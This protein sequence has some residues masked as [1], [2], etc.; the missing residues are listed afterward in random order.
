MDC[1]GVV[2]ATS[3]SQ[4]SIGT[5]PNKKFVR[6]II[7]YTILRMSPNS[8]RSSGVLTRL[9]SGPSSSSNVPLMLFPESEEPPQSS[10][11]TQLPPQDNKEGRMEQNVCRRINGMYSRF[12]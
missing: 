5:P 3:I 2:H 11:T 6:S 4:V 9:S 10:T 1:H 7:I 12:K 8:S